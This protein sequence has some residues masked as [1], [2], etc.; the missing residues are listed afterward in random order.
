MKPIALAASSVLALLLLLLVLRAVVRRLRLRLR[1]GGSRL[2]RVEVATVVLGTCMLRLIGADRR[3]ARFSRWGV[4]RIRLR[5]RVS[6][7]LRRRRRVGSRPAMRLSRRCLHDVAR[8]V[9]CYCPAPGDAADQQER[10]QLLALLTPSLQDDHLPS[11]AGHP[12]WPIN[13]A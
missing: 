12:V 8:R 13:L 9:E 11:H 1:L 10:L 7:A 6:L 3:L 2:L 4:V 5:L